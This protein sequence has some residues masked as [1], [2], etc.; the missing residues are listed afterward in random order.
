MGMGLQGE[1]MFRPLDLLLE[2]S[3]LLCLFD[4]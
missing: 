1:I 3:G 4:Y 2:L